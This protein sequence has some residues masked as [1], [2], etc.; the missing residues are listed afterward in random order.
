MKIKKVMKA[1]YILCHSCQLSPSNQASLTIFDKGET[2]SWEGE[3]RQKFI[4]F[5]FFYKGQ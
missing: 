3:G 1:Q 2:L 5:Q 4:T